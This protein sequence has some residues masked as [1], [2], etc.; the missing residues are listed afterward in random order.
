MSMGRRLLR[1][2]ARN[3]FLPFLL[4]PL[5]NALEIIPPK[6]VRALA[7]QHDVVFTS[8][9]ENVIKS[10]KLRTPVVFRALGGDMTHMPFEAQ[11]LQKA[12]ISYYFRRH[13]RRLS[14]IISYQEDIDW[15]ARFLGVNDKIEYFAV[16]T[17]VLHMRNSMCQLTFNELAKVY[18]SYR[19]VFFF[20]ARKNLDPSKPNY[21]GPEKALQALVWAKQEGLSDFRCV[22]TDHG[23]HGREFRA[24]VRE[25][26]L[27][28][29][30]DFY[31]PQPITILSA[32]MRQENFITINDVGFTKSHLTGIG[33]ECVSLGSLMIDSVNPEN[34]EFQRLYGPVPPPVY[35]A[36]GV[37]EIQQH[38]LNIANLSPD[39][40]RCISEQ[41]ENW[42]LLNLHWENQIAK[43]ENILWSSVNAGCRTKNGTDLSPENTRAWI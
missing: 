41:S 43:L 37:E 22:A 5:L 19:Q 9:P 30:F 17:D 20:P 36:F 3:Q 34:H 1:L 39:E 32:Y 35:S 10:L 27:E 14:T 23:L 16:P 6:C 21:K 40:R 8:G 26:G 2:S 7:E 38:M 24:M 42:A 11:N 15:A 25:L 18:G 12:Y 4:Q 29:R 31:Q 13:I 33:R 28:D